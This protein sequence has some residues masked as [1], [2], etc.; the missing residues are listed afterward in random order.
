M[1]AL[2]VATLEAREWFRPNAAHVG[3]CGGGAASVQVPVFSAREDG[4]LDNGWRCRRR[5]AHKGSR[6]RGSV[7]WRD[8]DRLS[9]GPVVI[10][11]SLDGVGMW[12]ESWGS[13]RLPGQI[14][15]CQIGRGVEL[16]VEMRVLRVEWRGCD[17]EWDRSRKSTRGVLRR[18]GVLARLRR[19]GKLG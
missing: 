8:M 4:D 7:R 5:T 15:K 17:A 10:V 16:G 2:T 14:K 9:T 6:N 11:L 12:V 18:V 3:S 13:L 19:E 1:K